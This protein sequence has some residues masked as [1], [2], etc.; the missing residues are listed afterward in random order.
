MEGFLGI[1]LFRFL[2]RV[3]APQLAG[4]GLDVAGGSGTGAPAGTSGAAEKEDANV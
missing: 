3:A 4:L 1:L 2:A